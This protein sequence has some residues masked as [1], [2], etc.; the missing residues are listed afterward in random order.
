MAQDD[1]W[2]FSYGTLQQ[3]EVQLAVFGRELEGCAD[4]LTSYRLAKLEITDPVVIATIGL[5]FHWI[6]DETGDAA[7]RIPGQA[8]RITP[9]DLAPADAYEAEDYKRVL[10]T[11]ESGRVAFV[12]VRA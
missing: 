8:L 4:V 2:L 11:L 7:D 1:I 5:T 3:R 9:A 6:L 12:Y 10:V